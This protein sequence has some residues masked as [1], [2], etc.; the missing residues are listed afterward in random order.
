MSG[1]L[2]IKCYFNVNKI[3]KLL[4][5]SGW[6]VED[7][8][9]L[10]T[11][12]NKNEKQS[13]FIENK[14]RVL[15]KKKFKDEIYKISKQK[16]NGTYSVNVLFTEILVML[17]SFYDSNYI[18]DEHNFLYDNFNTNEENGNAV[19]SVLNYNKEKDILN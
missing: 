11:L 2:E 12:K 17:A 3:K 16:A 5:N 1:H 7:G 13:D 15:F 6:F 9:F 19:L 8:S 14:N 4:E 10:K 18:V